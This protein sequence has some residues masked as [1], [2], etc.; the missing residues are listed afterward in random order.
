[1]TT[2]SPASPPRL[3]PRKDPE[4]Q[5]LRNDVLRELEKVHKALRLLGID[6][7]AIDVAAGNAPVGASYVTA[8]VSGAL[9]DERVL[10]A[11]HGIDLVDAGA[12]LTMTVDVDESELTAT[13]LGGFNEG[14]DDRVAALCVEGNGIALTYDDLANTFTI[15]VDESELAMQAPSYVTIANT[16]A[17]P[18]ERRLA[19]GNGID[20][21]DGGAGSTVTIAVDETELALNDVRYVVISGSAQLTN[22]RTLTAGHGIDLVDAGAN[23]TIT[24]DV[25][26][27]ELTGTLIPNVSRI[28]AISATP[29]TVSNTVAVTD[30]LGYSL[31]ANTLAAGRKLRIR[32]GGQYVNTSGSVRTY[33]MIISIGG[34]VLWEAA[35]NSNGSTAL[36]IPW[37][38]DFE[39]AAESNTLAHMHGRHAVH[40]T[41]A[42][43]TGLGANTVGQRSDA[44]ISSVRGGVTI[45]ALTSNRTITVSIAHSFAAATIILTRNQY[46]VELL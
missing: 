21:T 13:L 25:D 32:M 1:M 15:S 35:S 41:N 31:P 20:L 36:E 8:T 38:L 23:S 4:S 40:T 42:V 43:T 11:G 45:P 12:G 16:A 17:L 46:S 7:A 27:T 22:E 44:T 10:T 26:E 3:A 9:T 34:T 2:P 30:L 29:Q 5:A 28:L 33:N 6:I 24:V 14:V 39:I 18:N 37:E 19:E